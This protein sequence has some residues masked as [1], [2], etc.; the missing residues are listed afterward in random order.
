MKLPSNGGCQCEGVRYRIT[1]DPVVV[2]A[3][4]CT[5][6]QTQSGSAFG[7]AARFPKEHFELT[8]GELVSFDFPG[9]QGH[10][11]T[12]SFCQNCGTRIH[13]VHSRFPNL[14]SLKP[15]TL[16]DADGLIPAFHVYTR[17]AQPWVTIPDNVP[18]FETMPEDRSIFGGQ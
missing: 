15:G 7:L 9:T 12:N 4:H 1:S 18:S 2:Y 5:T 11:F 14:I 3:C 17:S 10:S 13:H 16:D 6:C 8:R